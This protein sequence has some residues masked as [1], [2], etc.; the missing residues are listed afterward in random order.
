MVVAKSKFV[1]CVTRWKT[2]IYISPPPS[3]E[4]YVSAGELGLIWLAAMC[5]FWKNSLFSVTSEK[6]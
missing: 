1:L 2:L 3:A 4:L 5:L 6:I